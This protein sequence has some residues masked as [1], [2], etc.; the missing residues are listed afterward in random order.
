MKNIDEKLVKLLKWKTNK[1]IKSFEIFPYIDENNVLHRLSDI[2]LDLLDSICIEKGWKWDRDTYGGVAI[3]YNKSYFIT[4]KD[5]FK[6]ALYYALKN[7]WRLK[8]N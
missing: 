8:D 5:D 1:K 4:R 6:E 2:N 3:F 7:E